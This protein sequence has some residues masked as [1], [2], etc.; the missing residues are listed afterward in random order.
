MTTVQHAINAGNMLTQAKDAL[1]HGAWLPWLESNF[2]GA[3]RTAQ[4][5]MRIARELPALPEGKAQR[6]ADLPLREAL[7]QLAEPRPET[8]SESAPQEMD[9]DPV[10][11]QWVDDC[12]RV[13]V[14]PLPSWFV[15]LATDIL[16]AG[17]ELPP[18]PPRLPQNPSARKMSNFLVETD[19]RFARLMGGALNGTPISLVEYS[20]WNALTFALKRDWGI[21]FRPSGITDKAWQLSEKLLRSDAIDALCGSEEVAS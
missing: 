10:F 2:D 4:A 18:P 3:A 5:Y 20:T 6:V 9:S 7:K 15:E 1:P 14:D 11:R 21:D 8:E 12:R 19:I 16:R 13:G 17:C